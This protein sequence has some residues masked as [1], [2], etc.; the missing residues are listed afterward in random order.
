MGSKDEAMTPSA[1]ACAHAIV[2]TVPAIVQAIR[3]QFIGLT[4]PTLSVLINGLFERWA[5]VPRGAP[6]QLQAHYAEPD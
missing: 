2:D 4:A 1:D 6:A 5:G 3:A